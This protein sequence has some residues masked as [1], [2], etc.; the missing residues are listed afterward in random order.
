LQGAFVGERRVVV[1][2]GC[3][4]VRTRNA[5]QSRE[6]RL[7]PLPREQ[8]ADGAIMWNSIRDHNGVY[9]D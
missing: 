1:G 2:D 4:R 3:G 5:R 9:G 7:R 8:S 6:V